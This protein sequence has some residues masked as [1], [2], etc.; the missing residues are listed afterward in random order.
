M[1]G[2]REKQPQAIV[3]HKG[4]SPTLLSPWATP[5]HG[6][7]KADQVGNLGDD[8][9]IKRRADGVWNRQVKKT[10]YSDAADDHH[11]G[12]HYQRRRAQ[13]KPYYQGKT[14]NA[15]NGKQHGDLLPGSIY[16]ARNQPY[17]KEIRAAGFC[18]A[19]DSAQRF[20]RRS[21]GLDH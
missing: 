17:P 1:S 19:N 12:R 5:Q 9:K 4:L 13:R 3:A 2:A 6:N 10:A 7:C 16:A 18:E 21:Q 20:R 14:G 15:D 11:Q 8:N